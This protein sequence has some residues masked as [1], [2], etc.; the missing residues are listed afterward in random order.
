MEDFYL[1]KNA[2][3]FDG[4]VQSS[5]AG[6]ISVMIGLSSTSCPM[7]NATMNGWMAF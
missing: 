3:M 5:F 4:R 7:L 2:R 6:S 1:T